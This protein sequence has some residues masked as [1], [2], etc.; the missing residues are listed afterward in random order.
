MVLMLLRLYMV[1]PVRSKMVVI[2]I[3]MYVYLVLWYIYIVYFI[4]YILITIYTIII[5]VFYYCCCSRCFIPT[6]GIIYI[7]TNLLFRCN[8]LLMILFCI[9]LLLPLGS[10]KTYSMFG[11]HAT[12]TPPSSTSTPPIES[13]YIS[14]KDLEGRG[15]VPRA[16]EEIFQAIKQRSSSGNSIIHAEVKVSYV[17]V[18]G[19]EVSDLLKYGARCGQSKVA[20]QQYVLSGAA[21]RVVTSME[22]IREILEIGKF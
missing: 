22:D 13:S 14:L 8:L 20:A 4:E 6:I 9:L 1:K 15:I 18:F 5:V 10:G 16:C 7:Y 19:D 12:S 17:E 21:E 3:Y 11:A 2:V